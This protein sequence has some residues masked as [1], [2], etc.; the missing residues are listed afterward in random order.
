MGGGGGAGGV[1]YSSNVVLSPSAT[2]YPIIVG[3]GG[4]GTPSGG[5]VRGISGSNSSFN[6]ISCNC[7][8]LLLI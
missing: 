3:A 1:I 4:A 5:N 7:N 6:G 2:T 8:G